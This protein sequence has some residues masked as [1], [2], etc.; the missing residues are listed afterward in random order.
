[1][2]PMRFYQI[3]PT[4]ICP[5]KAPKPGSPTWQAG[6]FFASEMPDAI[7]PSY[8]WPGLFQHSVKTRHWKEPGKN[9]LRLNVS[10]S[11][12]SEVY[13]MWGSYVRYAGSI[14]D[15]NALLWRYIRS[16]SD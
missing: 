12:T 15:I 8:S 9:E 10:T 3:A 5:Y 2:S 6:G 16:R 1:M 14:D 13:T 4:S 7:V 11:N